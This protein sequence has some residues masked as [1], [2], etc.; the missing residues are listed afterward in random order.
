MISTMPANYNLVVSPQ[1]KFQIY[2][3]PVLNPI[4]HHL[5][6]LLD[7]SNRQLM[8]CPHFL[9]YLLLSYILYIL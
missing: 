3:L 6:Y 8:T 5:S 1:G 2:Q 7:V 9:T 4:P